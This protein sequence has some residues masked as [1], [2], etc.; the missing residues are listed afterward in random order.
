[1]CS[2]ALDDREV[3]KLLLD[4]ADLEDRRQKQHVPAARVGT[5]C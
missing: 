5:A 2:L 1:M 4:G 3:Q